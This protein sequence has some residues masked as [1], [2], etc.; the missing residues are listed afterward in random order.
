MKTAW[1]A[2][3]GFRPMNDL[4]LPLSA[5]GYQSHPNWKTDPGTKWV[6]EGNPLLRV[7]E[8]LQMLLNDPDK[9]QGRGA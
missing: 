6:A 2:C 9:Y 5:E 4:C 1:P 7:I 8:E 3:Q